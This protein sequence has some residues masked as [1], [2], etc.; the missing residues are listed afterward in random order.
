[1]GAKRE[2]VKK[3]EREKRKREKKE[4]RRKLIEGEKR[5]VRKK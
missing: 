3:R 5:E 1:M 2:K 4:R